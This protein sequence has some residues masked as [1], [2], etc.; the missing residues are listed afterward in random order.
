MAS[1]AVVW[2]Q[3]FCPGWKYAILGAFGGAVVQA[4]GGLKIATGDG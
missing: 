1:S 3:V 2:I 4:D